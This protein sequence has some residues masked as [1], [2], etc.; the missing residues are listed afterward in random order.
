[1]A[2]PQARAIARQPARDPRLAKNAHPSASV[3]RAD[4]KLPAGATDTESAFSAQESAISRAERPEV[5]LHGRSSISAGMVG[6]RSGIARA[7]AVRGFAKRVSR[8]FS[9]PERHSATVALLSQ[10][11]AARRRPFLIDRRVTSSCTIEFCAPTAGRT[12]LHPRQLGDRYNRRWKYR[13]HAH[14]RFC[15]P[16]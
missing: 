12:R 9:A 1:M 2:R 6:S 13:A 8:I 7:P 11:A 15:R 3:D 4:D 14:S 5:L 16:E 10:T